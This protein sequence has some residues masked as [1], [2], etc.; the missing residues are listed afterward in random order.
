MYRLL[1][2]DDEPAIVDGLAQH[3]QENVEL[4]LDICK[5]H[6]AYEALE[7]VK[8]T[9]LDIVLSDIRM[10]GKSGLE[11]IDD[12]LF[13]WPSCRIILLTGHS[14]FDYVYTAI[15]KN[16]DAYL[17]K[18][19]GVPAISEAVKA[20]V[21]KLENDNRNK[22]LL[23]HAERQMLRIGPL[24]KKELFEALLHGESGTDAALAADYETI[25]D[26][27][28]LP[29]MP[30]LLLA[31]KVDDWGGDASY[32][33]KLKAYYAMH[34][35]L[36]SRL[37][38][39][40]RSEFLI[41]EHSSPVWF[42]QPE[43]NPSRFSTE[44]GGTDWRGMV[45]YLKG[46]LEAV[47]NASRSGL[48]LSVAFILSGDA[49][50]WED[51]AEEFG[52]MRALLKKRSVFGHPMAIIDL[53]A[54]DS[55]FGTGSGKPHAD[56]EPFSRKL[57]ELEKRMDEG[58][59]SG[60]AVML[61]EMLADI[62]ADLADHRMFGLERYYATLLVLLSQKNNHA[63]AEQTSSD[64][65]FAELLTELPT[66][67]EA[68]EKTLIELCRRICRIRREQH[69]NSENLLIERIHRFIEDHL[70]GDLSLARIAE[71]VFF[72]PSYLSRF[73]KQKTGR[74]LIEYINA[75]KAEAAAGMLKE[76]QLKVNEIA[77][78]LGFES[79]SYFTAFF[80]KTMG[81]T[82]QDYREAFIN[83]NNK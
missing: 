76:L 64:F 63:P 7:L 28:L 8:K 34:D 3:F 47:Q 60:T 51:I 72:N 52:R 13:Y 26:R 80:K 39:A 5:A 21:R 41:H 35:M 44:G 31:A 53:G 25:P 55:L 79:P 11:M 36:D 22:E 29:G 24:L 50:R 42:I 27:V 82:P 37:P 81:M 66:D 48:G 59:E 15:Q 61:A 17:L 20:A 4:E 54:P 71:V 73:Y 49:V 6:T 56:R 69:A 68:A 45:T 43:P 67:W 23:E 19:E 1:I 58:D 12:I 57:G 38:D 9:R 62:R 30:L 32:A 46:I 40:F 33:Q 10:P 77:L 2:V 70:G 14:E 65:L 18:T 83:R 75:T 16:V 74:N 78:K